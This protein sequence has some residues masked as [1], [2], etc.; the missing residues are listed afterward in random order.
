[1]RWLLLAAAGLSGPLS[2]E[3]LDKDST[4]FTPITGGVLNVALETELRDRLISLCVNS[5]EPGAGEPLATQTSPR[6]AAFDYPELEEPWFASGWA[7]NDAERGSIEAELRSLATRADGLLKQ[8]LLSRGLATAVRVEV[9]TYKTFAVLT[10]LV[11]QTQRGAQV[12]MLETVQDAMS[13]LATAEPD[14]ELRRVAARYLNKNR[15][16]VVEFIPKNALDPAALSV[17]R[18]PLTNPSTN[19]NKSPLRTKRSTKKA[20]RAHAV[21]RG[22]T[23]IGIARRYKTSVRA[24]VEK[25][26]LDPRRPIRVGQKI[27]VA[28]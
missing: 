1:M 17:R 11:R 28:R 27:V 21:K 25:N 6:Y 19:P 26:Q 3:V 5:R 20:V 8:D 4:V 18:A 24:L 9:A 16:S 22:D 12:D 23:L 10:V 15:R 7:V 2:A 14:Q 13:W